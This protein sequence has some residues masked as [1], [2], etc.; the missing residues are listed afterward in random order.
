LDGTLK[1][2]PLPLGV[3]ILATPADWTEKPH[4]PSNDTFAQP[5]V[6]NGY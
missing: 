4:V 1:I 6:Y 2:N 3:Y 5:M